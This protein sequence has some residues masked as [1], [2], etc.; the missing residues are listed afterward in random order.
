M[1]C[2]FLLVGV[3]KP[4][5]LCHLFCPRY[6]LWVFLSRI[7]PQHDK[8]NKMTCAPSEVSDQLGHPPSLIRVFAVRMRKYW[9]LSYPLS[10]LW[11]VW[12][13]WVDA[14]ADLSLWWA[15]RSFWWFCHE[16]AYLVF[17]CSLS[18]MNTV[19]VLKI[20]TPEKIAVIILKFEHGGFTME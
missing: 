6:I 16:V 13:D 10:T 20:Q 4:S 7:E 8:T 18:T 14:Q 17:S 1:K 3:Y 2:F 9:V 12:S 15:Q 19:K 5:S 11:R